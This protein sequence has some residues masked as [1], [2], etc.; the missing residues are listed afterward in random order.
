MLPR[1][2]LAIKGKGLTI[3]VL[4]VMVLIALGY[5]GF[6]LYT[7]LQTDEPVVITVDVVGAVHNPG[8]YELS[9]DSRVQDA[10]H[11]AGGLTPEADESTINRAALLEDGMRL[12]I[13]MTPAA[14]DDTDTPP[15]DLEEALVNINTA[16]AYTLQRLPGIGSVTAEKII[17]YR[18]SHGLFTRV[19]DLQNIEG[20]GSG[21]LEKI[22]A[23]V[24][25]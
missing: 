17:E 21:T 2:S 16:D 9:E 22:K 14:P 1:P 12:F 7:T 11:A 24:E 4:V 19:E 8:V 23:L 18:S 6:W 15:V 5:G 20:I 10:I 3:F 25:L 13:S